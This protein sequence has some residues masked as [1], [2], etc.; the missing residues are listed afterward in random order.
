MTATTVRAGPP[1]A[2]TSL[3]PVH[4]ASRAAFWALLCR[5]FT[6]LK[7]GRTEFLASIIMQP[8]LLTFVFT[9]M[10]PA[11]DQAVGGAG[12]AFATLLMPGL[13]AQAFVF[14][15]IF[16]VG[17]PLVR[18]LLVTNE[19]E[20]RV[21]APTTISVFALEKMVAGALQGVL[22]GLVVFPVAALVPATPIEL[23]VKWPVVLTV[24]PLACLTAA[25]LGVTLG[26]TFKPRAMPYL[27]STVAM[28]INFFGATFFSWAA[29]TP[30]PW[31][32]YTLLINPL[33]YMSEGLRAGLVT[34]EH[35][36]LPW[37]YLALIV[38]LALFTRLGIRGLRRRVLA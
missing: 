24:T 36:P 12:V 5:D 18:E 28:P 8:L 23:D 20:D 37:I 35:M 19:L 33:V 26:T 4:A 6:V 30:L 17:A 34:S 1:A 9:Y 7:K 32:K 27:F 11:L 16:G 14:Q 10:F 3:R 38:F 31:L 25:A 21:M 15:G 2:A 13:V 29:L 22:A